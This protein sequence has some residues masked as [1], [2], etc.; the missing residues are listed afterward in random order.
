MFSTGKNSYCWILVETDF[1]NFI[2]ILVKI[3]L[4]IKIFS[5]LN[6]THNLNIMKSINYFVVIKNVNVN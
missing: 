1:L 5:R 2:I 6:K 3:S 4:R